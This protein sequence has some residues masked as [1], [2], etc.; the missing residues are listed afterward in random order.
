MTTETKPFSIE[1]E[2]TAAAQQ[3]DFNAVQHWIGLGANPN[4][5]DGSPYVLAVANNHLDIVNFLYPLVDENTRI[6]GLEIAAYN[7]NNEMFNYL[8][9]YDHAKCALQNLENSFGEICAHA[10]ENEIGL[11]SILKKR[12]ANDKN[13]AATSQIKRKICN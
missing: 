12:V 6:F 2:L 3:G 5:K 11:A 8:Y 4:Y 10:V 13:Q 1:S 7:E 9:Q